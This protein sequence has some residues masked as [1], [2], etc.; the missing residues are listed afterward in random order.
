MTYNEACQYIT[1]NELPKK[2]KINKFK[3]EYAYLINE[4]LIYTVEFAVKFNLVDFEVVTLDSTTIEASVDEY[5]RLKYEQIIYLENLIKKYGK[6]KGKKSI[7]KRLRRF[8]YYNELDD[9]L[10]DLVEEIYKKLNKHGREL[11]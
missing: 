11:I 5:R 3:N 4:F 6:S 10:V 2:S 1:N 9:D 8:F 7:W